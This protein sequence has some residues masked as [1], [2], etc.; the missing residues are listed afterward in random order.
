[1]S[2]AIRIRLLRASM[3]AI[4]AVLCAPGGALAQLASGEAAKPLPS[5]EREAP[6]VEDGRRTVVRLPANLFR[7]TVGVFDGANVNPAI[8]GSFA[9]GF[10]AL[11][12]KPIAR[13]LDDPDST[14]G[15]G[16]ATGGRP[17]WAG[18]VAATLFVGGRFVHA[19][20]FRK[21]SYD[22]L[23]AYLVNL[24]YTE[25]LKELVGRTRPNGQDDKSFP[26]GHASN[27]FALAAVAD[28]HYGWKVGVPAYGVAALISVSRLQ[29]NAHYLSD[30]M[31]G[32]TLGYI[33]GRTVVRVNDSPLR[34]GTSHVSVSPVLAR[35]ARA[36]VVDVSWR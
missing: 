16:L 31:G 1:M 29:Q 28:R 15:T 8:L 3:P 25:L 24:G 19:T 2:D 33:V 21:A 32:A 27:A 18:A 20:R 7:A 9:T 14:L 12:D 23:E 35:N 13:A 30:V 22:W 5:Q 26:S 10:A 36:L 17:R 11:Y 6:V 34:R 4:L